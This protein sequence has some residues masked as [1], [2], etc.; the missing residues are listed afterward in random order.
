MITYGVTAIQNKPSL[1][2]E[3]VLG[4][5]VDKRAH[6]TLGYFISSKYEKYIKT[7]IQKI[8]QDEKMAKLNTLKHHQDIDFLELGVDDG[9]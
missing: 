4:E 8:E 3:M 6:K 1:L 7:V 2:K 5:I 9:L